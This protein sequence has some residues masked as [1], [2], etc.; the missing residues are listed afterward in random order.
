VY[1]MAAGDAL[2]PGPQWGGEG[3]PAWLRLA[4][5]SRPVVLGALSVIVLAPL[6]SFRLLPLAF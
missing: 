1:L 2:M 6:S 3:L 4:L 5:R